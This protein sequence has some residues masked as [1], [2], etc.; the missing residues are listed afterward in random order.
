MILEHARNMELSYPHQSDV[1]VFEEKL[2]MKKKL[3]SLKIFLGRSLLKSYVEA[4][5]KAT[6]SFTIGVTVAHY[7]SN[8]DAFFNTR[9]ITRKHTETL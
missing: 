3:V 6:L 1:S 5:G 8:K 2:Y 9:M 7:R 4:S